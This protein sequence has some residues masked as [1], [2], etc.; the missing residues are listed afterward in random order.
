MAAP[1]L[2]VIAVVLG[3][4]AVAAAFAAGRMTRSDEASETYAPR[5]ANAEVEVSL[6]V[7]AVGRVPA[8][9]EQPQS[10]APA[11]TGEAPA[12]GA[13]SAPP[14]TG[15]AAPSGTTGGTGTTGGGGGSDEPVRV[16]GGID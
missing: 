6:P 16:G 3:L 1:R 15:G 13:S 14:S 5:V 9:K 7:L 11:S 2:V 10:L 8:L 4:V 12:E